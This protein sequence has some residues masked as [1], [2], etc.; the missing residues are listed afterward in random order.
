[1]D[2][3][4]QMEYRKISESSG[5]EFVKERDGRFKTSWYERNQYDIYQASKRGLWAAMKYLRENY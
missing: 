3:H 2:R 1:M 5:I 4:R